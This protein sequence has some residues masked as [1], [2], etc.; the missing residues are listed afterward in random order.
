ML[1]FSRS[2]SDVSFAPKFFLLNR[3]EESQFVH[4]EDLKQK[5]TF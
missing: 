5:E 3:Y 1:K 2:E 4:D